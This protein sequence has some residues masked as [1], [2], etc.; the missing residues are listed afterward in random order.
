M[1]KN[2]WCFAER[3]EFHKQNNM[4]CEDKVI[5][6]EKMGMQYIALADGA[7]S[8]K[9]C[10]EGAECAVNAIAEYVA[11]NF[12]RLLSESLIKAK[13]TIW[14]YVIYSIKEISMGRNIK[15][16][17]STLLF[18]GVKNGKYIS[19]HLGDGFIAAKSKTTFKVISPPMNGLSKR[20]TYLTTTDEAYKFVRL[21][22]GD[23][24]YT[25]FLLSSDGCDE[26]IINEEKRVQHVIEEMLEK[27]HGEKK[28]RNYLNKRKEKL[29]DDYSMAF[30]T[31]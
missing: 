22:R 24:R 31:V 4:L 3:G 18:V 21:L 13:Y 14:S 28:L 5:S 1:K 25:A 26:E 19:F 20:Y 6:G 15:M 8:L 11:D 9:Y 27:K 23:D 16:F 12:E 2:H 10:A 29:Q 7:G 17:G 30:M